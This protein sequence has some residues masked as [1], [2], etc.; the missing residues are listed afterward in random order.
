MLGQN[1]WFI[2]TSLNEFQKVKIISSVFSDHNGMKL[3]INDYDKKTE[4]FTEM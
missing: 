1:T 3:D 4:E 2:K